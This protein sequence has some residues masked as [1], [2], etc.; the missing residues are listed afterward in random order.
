MDVVVWKQ[1]ARQEFQQAEPAAGG[2]SRESTGEVPRV[3]ERSLQMHVV[4]T[5]H[6]G[7]MCWACIPY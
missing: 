4:T 2:T 3:A 1:Q 5:A 6:S 7:F